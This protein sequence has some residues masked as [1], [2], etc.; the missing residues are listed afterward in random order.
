M[1]DLRRSASSPPRFMGCHGYVVTFLV[2]ETPDTAFWVSLG[3]SLSL[4]DVNRCELFTL[5]V[6]FFLPLDPLKRL[7]G[8][9]FYA[10]GNLC[11][12]LIDGHENVPT[13]SDH[14]QSLF[15]P[16]R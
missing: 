12:S 16:T 4:F 14:Q 10:C 6:A 15:V 2:K 3:V 9:V 7:Y 5:S 8:T 11:R 1:L 13:F